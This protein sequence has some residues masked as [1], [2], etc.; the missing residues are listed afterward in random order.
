LDVAPREAKAKAPQPRREIKSEIRSLHVN[1]RW[2][3][4]I[5]AT[6]HLPRGVEL[7]ADDYRTG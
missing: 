7:V 5:Q 4:A 2:V 3:L 6:K 1:R